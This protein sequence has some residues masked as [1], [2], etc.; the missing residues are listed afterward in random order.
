MRKSD[1]PRV[2]GW[3][4]S[5]IV[6]GNSWNFPVAGAL[7]PEERRHLLELDPPVERVVG[8][9]EDHEPRP[10]ADGLLE[11]RPRGLAPVGPVV[12]H[13]EQVE[14]AQGARV[15]ERRGR[16]GSDRHVEP[17]RPPQKQPAEG[18]RHLPVV[19][20]LPGEDERADLLALLAHRC[21]HRSG[22]R[23]RRGDSQAMEVMRQ[24]RCEARPT[25]EVGASGPRPARKS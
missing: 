24:P 6:T 25:A 18:R 11:V 21:S 9:V 16:I 5:T 1:R 10:A 3:S 14:P 12:I 19:V 17:P 4:L 23:S 13:K 20:V 7:A 22:G 2:T 15:L 8:R